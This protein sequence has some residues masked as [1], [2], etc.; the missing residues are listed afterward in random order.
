[1]AEVYVVGALQNGVN[2]SQKTLGC[3]WSLLLGD[4]WEVEAG[5]TSG[6]SQFD[7]PADRQY[8]GYLWAQPLEFH[9]RASTLSSWPQ[10]EVTVFAPDRRSARQQVACGTAFLPLSSGHH[11]VEVPCW[12]VGRELARDGSGPRAPMVRPGRGGSVEPPEGALADANLRVRLL[13]ESAGTVFL[14][15]WVRTQGFEERGV[16]L[17]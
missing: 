7:T 15:I 6:L 11:H 14:D 16:A 8:E 2:F 12:S 13:T 9:L 10:F 4:G 5:E 1:M 17:G 3:G